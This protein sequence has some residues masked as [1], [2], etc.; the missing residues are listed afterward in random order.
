MLEPGYEKLSELGVADIV[1]DR[2][3]IF[4]AL[5]KYSVNSI[6]KPKITAGIKLIRVNT[7]IVHKLVGDIHNTYKKKGAV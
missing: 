6:R 7:K 3:D 4:R 5:L 1:Q 2:V